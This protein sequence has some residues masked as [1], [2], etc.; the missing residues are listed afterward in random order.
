MKG[1]P[2][3][4]AKKLEELEKRGPENGG[5]RKKKGAEDGKR[6]RKKSAK[7]L[8]TMEAGISRL[9]EITAEVTQTLEQR[10]TKIEAQLSRLEAQ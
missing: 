2:T 9:L 10:S 8:T 3:S 4:I 1:F 5:Q 7:K 6:E